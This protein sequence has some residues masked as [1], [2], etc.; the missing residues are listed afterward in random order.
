MCLDRGDGSRDT[1]REKFERD[2]SASCP[3]ARERLRSQDLISQPQTMKADES[4][5]CR[6]NFVVVQG[7][8]SD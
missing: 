1:I 7:R 4:T 6:A 3:E 2:V 5:A 8:K